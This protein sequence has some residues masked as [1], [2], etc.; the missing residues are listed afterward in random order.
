MMFAGPSCFLVLLLFP[1]LAFSWDPTGH[2]VVAEIAYS[3]LT[4]DA[5]QQVDQI[6]LAGDGPRYS[7]QARFLY[8][9]ILPDIW[10]ET[11]SSKNHWHYFGKPWSVD[12]VPTTAALSSNMVTALQDNTAILANPAAT[13]N[14]KFVS[15]A[16]VEHLAGDAHQP[17]HCLNRF[18]HDFPQGDMGG[19]LFSIQNKYASNL[20]AYWDQRAHGKKLQAQYLIR[21]FGKQ[22][23]DLNFYTWERQCY[24]IAKKYAY[25]HLQPNDRLPKSYQKTA[26][27]IANQQL[28]LA[29]YR[30]AYLLNSIFSTASP[31]T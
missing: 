21:T 23:S 31:D 7:G 13:L 26:R 14:Q 29:G 25:D 19:N 15:L 20:H 4:A 27:E 9:A 5:K 24:D 30:L 12:G 11:D 16:W 10:R 28:T 18:S 22:S 17:L 6:T 3:L 8:A 1:L 2:K